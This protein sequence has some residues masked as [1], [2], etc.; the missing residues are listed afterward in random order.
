MENIII[1]NVRKCFIEV[2]HDDSDPGSYIVRCWKKILW[3]RKRI[4]SDWFTNK[5]QALEF[6]NEMNRT[7]KERK[8]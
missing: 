6:A 8:H 3:F 4:S 7:F 1:S 2:S 5:E